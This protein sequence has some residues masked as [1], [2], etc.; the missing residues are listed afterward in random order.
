MFVFDVSSFI[1]YKEYTDFIANLKS[2]FDEKRNSLFE[3]YNITNSAVW[4][5]RPDEYTEFRDKYREL[6]QDVINEIIKKFRKFLP[7]NCLIYEFGSLT[8]FTDRIESD[9]LTKIT[10]HA[11]RHFRL[12]DVCTC[13]GLLPSHSA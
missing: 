3:I 8:K 9:K 11:K 12:N 5:N 7:N 6:R 10:K 13:H 1:S 2:K 4:N